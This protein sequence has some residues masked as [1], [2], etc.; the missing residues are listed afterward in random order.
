MFLFIFIFLSVA[1]GAAPLQTEINKFTSNPFYKEH[2]ATVV[3]FDSSLLLPDM[4]LIASEYADTTLARMMNKCH[5]GQITSKDAKTLVHTLVAV[6][7]DDIDSDAFRV[8]LLTKCSSLIPLLRFSGKDMQAMEVRLSQVSPTMLD[9]AKQN[10]IKLLVF[11]D[12]DSNYPIIQESI[13]KLVRDMKPL[14]AIM[15]AEV[16]LPINNHTDVTL[17]GGFGDESSSFAHFY[18]G[19]KTRLDACASKNSSD[20][21]KLGIL[22][23]TFNKWLSRNPQGGIDE[24][25]TLVA[26]INDE[27]NRF[28]PLFL[29]TPSHAYSGLFHNNPESGK[30]DLVLCNRGNMSLHSG[31]ILF[32]NGEWNDFVDLDMLL[33]AIAED[34]L[35]TVVG[36][37]F[38][39]DQFEVLLGEPEQTSGNCYLQAGIMLLKATEKLLG[40]NVVEGIVLDEKKRLI[41]SLL[42]N[43]PQGHAM[44]E[45]MLTL[46]AKCTILQ[47]IN[48]FGFNLNLDLYYAQAF[49]PKMLTS[50]FAAVQNIFERCDT[51]ECRLLKLL[52]KGNQ[53]GFMNLYQGLS[54]TD[55]QG[56]KSTKDRPIPYMQMLVSSSKEPIVLTPSLFDLLLD[57]QF[58]GYHAM[59]SGREYNLSGIFMDDFDVQGDYES[60]EVFLNV[61][62][63]YMQDPTFDVQDLIGNYGQLS[64][65]LKDYLVQHVIGPAI[66]RSFL[67]IVP[68]P[69]N[70]HKGIITNLSQHSDSLMPLVMDRE[71]LNLLEYYKN[72]ADLI[73]VEDNEE[74][75]E[76]IIAANTL[77]LFESAL[78]RS[79]PDASTLMKL[80]IEQNA[81]EDSI[82]EDDE[83]EYEDEADQ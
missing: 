27:N 40:L 37:I 32:K 67:R 74:V 61:L 7:E 43:Y 30:L 35:R 82:N 17:D 4:H 54:L 19:I 59:L 6:D 47:P 9:V 18:T 69:W 78:V 34:N 11:D 38:E 51:T 28:I 68:W 57:L 5:A 72:V 55:R 64:Q 26:D 24:R 50:S 22:R 29:E 62:S 73:K 75:R 12:K 13:L 70:Y 79:A 21:A 49:Q 10:V 23:A 71:I 20:D 41:R 14:A 65:G 16:I 63:F 39:S 80:N 3:A 76:E 2:P 46:L 36:Q 58:G 66:A 53:E 45:Q 8:D 15:E 81:S 31:C 25:T 48:S 33:Y 60:D 56:L 52:R 42:E 1:R 77:L 44:R 83:N